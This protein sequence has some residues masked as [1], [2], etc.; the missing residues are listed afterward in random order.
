MLVWPSRF[1]PHVCL[2]ANPLVCAVPCHVARKLTVAMVLWHAGRKLG[3]A[4]PLAFLMVH[5]AG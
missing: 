4:S 1:D 2:D 5:S 3:R